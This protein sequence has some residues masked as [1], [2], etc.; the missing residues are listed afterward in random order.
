MLQALLNPREI[1]RGVAEILR[2]PRRIKP[3]EAAASYLRNDKGPWFSTLT[4]YVVEPLDHLGSRQYQGIV[5]VGPARTGKSFGLIGA[6]VCYVITCA[7]G[8]MLIV[9]MSK[10]TARD[11]SLTDLDRM[12]RHSP[13]L[14]AR[15]SPRPRDDNVFDKFFRSGISLKLGWPAVSQLSAKTLQYVLITDYDR[16]ENRDDVDGEGPM[17]DLAAKRVETYMSRGKCLAES[18]PGEEYTKPNWSPSTPHE[19]PPALGI[20]SLYNRGTRARWYWR[21]LHCRQPFEAKPGLDLFRLPIFDELEEIVQQTDLMTYAEQ[22]AVVVCTACGGVHRLSDRQE[23]NLNGRWIHEG[24]ILLP[25][26]TIDG[27]RRRT[28][29]ASYWL[30]GVAAAYQRWDLLLHKYLQAVQTYV[31]TGDEQPL[32]NTT[33]GD[34]AYPY[35]PRAIAKRRGVEQLVQR[36]ENWPKG[37]MPAAARFLTA[38]V[39]VQSGRFVVQVQAWGKGLEHWLVDRFQITAS[40][41]AEGARYAGLDPASYWEDWDLLFDAIVLKTYPV[42]GIEGIL[43]P[44]ALTLVDSGGKAGVTEKAYDF[45][46]RARAQQLGGRVM[47]VKGTGHKDAARCTMVWPDARERSDRETGG[48]GDVPVWLINTNVM[49]DGVSGA[50]SRL[51][52]GPGYFHLPEWLPKDIFE[53]L[54]SEV[55]GEK[56]WTKQRGIPNEAFDLAVYNRAAVIALEAEQINWDSPP[57]WA[58]PIEERKVLGNNDPDPPARGGRRMRHSGI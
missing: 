51:A 45:W 37:F 50:L 49:K 5:F 19:A 57:E 54:V 9:H 32:K 1:S 39:D 52:H 17:W 23:L 35:L 34:Q 14:Q 3:S 44:V 21:C 58:R 33:S 31:R 36:A 48:R 2:P 6:G 25:D 26:G 22:H 13:E 15:L 20:L 28:Q 24:E 12:I 46:R 55:R 42:H 38:A 56:G 4:P 10:D 11:Y 29:I 30:G 41:R 7:P 53:E 27:E 16:P 40:S 43:V 8:D 47:L 18:S